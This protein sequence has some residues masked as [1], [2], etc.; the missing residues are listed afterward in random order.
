VTRDQVPIGVIEV[1]KALDLSRRQL[2]GEPAIHTTCSSDKNSTGMNQD[3]RPPG[4]ATTRSPQ[5][6]SHR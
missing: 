5:D 3:R 6:R 1:E 4:N 2:A